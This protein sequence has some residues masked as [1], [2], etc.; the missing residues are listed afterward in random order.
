MCF[1]CEKWFFVYE[2]DIFLCIDD[3]NVKLLWVFIEVLVRGREMLFFFKICFFKVNNV[4]VEIGYDKRKFEEWFEEKK[5]G[6]VVE[7]IFKGFLNVFKFLCF[8]I[9]LYFLFYI[10]GI[11][12]GFYFKNFIWFVLDFMLY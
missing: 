3:L 7:I 6:V 5:D 10:I 4:F 11:L 2:I 8:L 9:F 1:F 12:S